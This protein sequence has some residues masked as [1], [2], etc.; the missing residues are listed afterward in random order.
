[1]VVG[2]PFA[3]RQLPSGAALSPVVYSERIFGATTTRAIIG[4]RPP[5]RAFGTAQAR[6]Q[7][8]VWWS[9]KARTNGFRAKEGRLHF[10]LMASIAPRTTFL[11]KSPKKVTMTTTTTMV[12]YHWVEDTLEGLWHDVY[13][14]IVFWRCGLMAPVFKLLESRRLKLCSE[15]KK[16]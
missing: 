16:R 2:H 15:R 11:K 3:G 5:M 12:F 1:M 4:G 13:H 7:P 9:N 14:S 6:C 8:S 10:S